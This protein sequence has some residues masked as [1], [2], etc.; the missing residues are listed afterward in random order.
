MTF[1]VFMLSLM[2]KSLSIGRRMVAVESVSGAREISLYRFFRVIILATLSLEFIGS[3][4]LYFCWQGDRPPAQAAYFSVF[5]SISAFCTAGFSLFPDSLVSFRNN[6]PVNLIISLLSLL[7][8]IGFIVIIDSWAYLRNVMVRKSPRRLSPHS[9]LVLLV[10]AAVIGVGS[11]S[12]LLIE[13]FQGL[14]PGEK[15]LSS[16]FQ[17]VSASTTDGFNTVNIGA[18]VPSALFILCVLMLIGAGPGSTGGGLKVSTFGTLTL[19]FRSFILGKEDVNFGGRRIPDGTI[20]EAFYILFVFL[21]ILAFD[22]VILAGTESAS[23]LELVFEI[24]SALGNTGLSMG[25]TPNLSPIGKIL[26]SL[27]MF[28]GRVGPLTLGLSLLE[29]RQNGHYHFAEAKIYVG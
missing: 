8:G 14:R 21:A 10:T 12:I 24:S 1:F 4:L 25:V 16:V 28:A 6:I 29:R 23:F 3:I 18:M 15:I 2:K 26:I 17:A 22:S 11:I 5:H 19:A 27:T 13:P 20:M 9:K 7:G